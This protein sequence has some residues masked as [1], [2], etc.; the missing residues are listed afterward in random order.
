MIEETMTEAIEEMTTEDIMIEDIEMMI[1]E[2]PLMIDI[3]MSI[4]NLYNLHKNIYILINYK[5]I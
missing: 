3:E 2:D 5:K 1:E 4:Y